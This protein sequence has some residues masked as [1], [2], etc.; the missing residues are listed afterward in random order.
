M[1]SLTFYGIS[2]LFELEETPKGHLV[3][4]PHNE[5]GHLQL[6]QGAQ[7]PIQPFLLKDHLVASKPVTG[8]TEE[9]KLKCLQ[10]VAGRGQGY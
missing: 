4:L 8:D 9:H 2:E 10:R 6:E 7:S 1:A 5:E 3:Q